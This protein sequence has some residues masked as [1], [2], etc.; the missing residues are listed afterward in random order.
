MMRLILLAIALTFTLYWA[1]AGWSQQDPPAPAPIRIEA[2]RMES[3][4]DQ[5]VIVFSGHV[6]ANQENLIINADEMTVRYTGEKIG[7]GPAA[8][9]GPDAGGLT[10]QIDAISA[11]GNVKIVQGNWIATGNTMDFDSEKRIVILS[12]NA[13]A[14]QDQNMV[15][16]EKIILY[17]DEGRSVVERSSQEGERVKA[18]IYPS[19]PESKDDKKTP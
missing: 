11:Q 8:A 17:L 13:R 7:Q 18:F 4:Q 12:G 9:T 15:S 19:S 10:Q 2:D 6:Q 16:G 5:S 3:A 1:A 14:W